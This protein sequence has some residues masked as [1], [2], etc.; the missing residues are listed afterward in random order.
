MLSE[1]VARAVRELGFKTPTPIQAQALPVLLGAATDFIGQAATGTGKTAAFGLPLVER[2]D[3]AHKEVQG[4]VLC[5]TRELAL[6][7]SGQLKLFGK[8]KGVKTLPIYGGAPYDV[9]FDGLKRHPSIVAGTPGRILELIGRGALN[10]GGVKTVV[11]DESDEMIS[12]GFKEDLEKILQ[13]T[14]RATANI[15]LFSATMS[16]EIRRIADQYLRQ[17]KQAQVNRTEVLS[18]TVSQ[19]WYLAREADKPRL[20]CDLIEAADEFYGIIF[21][22]TKALVMDLN[23]LLASRGYRVDCLHGDKTQ[24]DRERTMRAFRE[25][26]LSVLVCTDVASRGLD[27]KD[28]THVINYSL[29]R[30]SEVYVH[31]IGRTARSGQAGT[32][33]SLVTPGNRRQMEVIE[34]LTK[35]KMTEG[36][37]PTRA[38][39]GAKKVSK[40]LK[41]FLAQ[42]HHPRAME[43]LGDDWQAATEE[44]DLREILGRFIVMTAPEVFEDPKPIPSLMPSPSRPAHP[45]GEKHK[46]QNDYWKKRKEAYKARKQSG[47]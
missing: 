47:R 9:Q 43:L 38:E 1:P 17:P 3:P 7:V 11:L 27:V 2:A 45:G 5:P 30:E 22:Q 12:M 35:S 4:L 33:I 23:E 15:W 29:P 20:V 16:K 34:K 39:I 31:R 21:C 24:I 10:V 36:R 6:Q 40:L 18:S 46:K 26:K 37:L 14:P 19:V 42:T 8:N 32:A 13:A 25:K 41:K 44:M 28:V